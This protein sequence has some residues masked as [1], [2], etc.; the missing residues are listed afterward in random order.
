MVW[1]C[2]HRNCLSE[3]GASLHLSSL[4]DI[5]HILPRSS[6]TAAPQI[7]LELLNILI[8]SISIGIKFV[9]APPWQSRGFHCLLFQSLAS[10][11]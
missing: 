11:I 7:A 3:I 10:K 9:H 4:K 8:G 1:I 6:A 5:V 2:A